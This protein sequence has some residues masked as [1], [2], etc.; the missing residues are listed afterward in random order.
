MGRKAFLEFFR[1][2]PRLGNPR[3]IPLHVRHENR[4]SDVGKL[5]GHHLQRHR[6]TG[7]GSSRNT[8]VAI[9]ISGKNVLR[10]APVFRIGLCDEKRF[11]NGLLWFG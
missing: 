7:T 9:G 5:F 6:L 2:R 10:T 4:Y 3:E 8:A 11:H 1:Q